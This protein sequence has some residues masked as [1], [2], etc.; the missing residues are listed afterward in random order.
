MGMVKRKMMEVQE[1]AWQAFEDGIKENPYVGQ[2]W[3]QTWAA[4]WEG[5]SNDYGEY[6]DEL[7]EKED[8][9]KMIQNWHVFLRSPAAVTYFDHLDRPD[10]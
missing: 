5:R 7:Q 6:L 9:L 1:E 8:Y 4:A 2:S 10:K 3:E